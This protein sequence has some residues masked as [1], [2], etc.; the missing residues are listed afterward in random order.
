LLFATLC[1]LPGTTQAFERD[2]TLR[3]VPS[4]TPDV[5]GYLVYA[6]NETTQVESVLDAGFVEPGPDGVAHTVVAL[7]AEHSFLVGMTAYS[8]SIESELSNLIQ[9]P[10]ETAACSDPSVCDDGLDC[11]SDSCDAAG[12]LHTPLPDG[13]GCDDGY[14]DTVNDQCVAGVC[15]GE[16]VVCH[17]DLDCD[18]GDVC[19]GLEMCGDTECFE[20]VPL[21]CG[22]PP[23][24]A[25][26]YCDPQTG[27]GLAPAQDGTPCDDGIDATA[28]D[29]CWGGVCEGTHSSAPVTVDA[30]SPQEA[31]PG[32]HML[33]IHGAGFEIGVTL[34]FENGK[35]RAPRVRSLVL[36]DEQTLAADVEVSRKGPK[37][38]RFWDVVVTHPNQTQARLNGGLRIDP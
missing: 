32:L 30:I 26:A 34:H 11:T 5:T 19:N 13:S 25:I 6:T 23:V 15:E 3:F 7:D 33:T 24:C 37:R 36:V 38:S 4:V 14:V 18:D 27:C 9:I 31:R 20:G 2:V 22:A 12:C 17:D 28:G 16:W 35:G 21:D 10:P 29:S 1:A 8:G